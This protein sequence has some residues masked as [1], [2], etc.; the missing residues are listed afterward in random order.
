[1]NSL[2]DPITKKKKTWEQ[3]DNRSN[4]EPHTF[5]K[6]IATENKASLFD[7][8]LWR[9][10]ISVRREG[11]ARELRNFTRIASSGNKIES[12]SY[13]RIA[14][15][16][17]NL[18]RVYIG[19]SIKYADRALSLYSSLHVSWDTLRRRGG[20]GIAK[21][22]VCRGLASWFVAKQDGEGGGEGIFQ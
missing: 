15:M 16:Y 19:L 2:L 20:G 10:W 7:R 12:K 8:S 17:Y 6:R 1:M 13:R 3:D 5:L 14:R 9:K 21:M 22:R 4:L 18:L 11:L